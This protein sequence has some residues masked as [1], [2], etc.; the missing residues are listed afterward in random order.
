MLVDSGEREM[1]MRRID[2]SR[3]PSKIAGV[4]QRKIEERL[5]RFHVR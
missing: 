1:T 4:Q 2:K 5:N 3:Y